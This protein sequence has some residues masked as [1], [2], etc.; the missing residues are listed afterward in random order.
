M[1]IETVAVGSH[2]LEVQGYSKIKDAFR[3]DDS[4]FSGKFKV[5]GHTWEILCDPWGSDAAD[6]VVVNL[7]I[8]V[9]RVQPVMARFSFALLGRD[10]ETSEYMEAMITGQYTFTSTGD[11]WSGEIIEREQFE[12]PLYLKDDRF[13]IRC[14]V[15]IVRGR[16]FLRKA[17]TVR[18]PAAPSPE[19]GRHLGGLLTNSQVGGDVT[20]KVGGELITAHKCI[21]AASSPVFKVEF[22]GPNPGND[23]N[24]STAAAAAHIQ[25]EDMKPEVF[26]AM[27]HFI[28]TDSLL[29]EIGHYSTK[30]AT[31][32]GLI[33]AA[34]RYKV[35]R[36][37]L[38]CGDKLCN[39]VDAGTAA[40]LLL[41]AKKHG[42][43]RLKETC[44]R[45]LRDLLADV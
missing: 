21:L 14:D 18:I 13:R 32:Q 17:A 35:D 34:D 11:Y 45:Y 41:L 4:T 6:W 15:A 42:C 19:L 25:I 43:R 38:I 30:G 44:M 36:L 5:G 12:S 40:T 16:E 39:Y 28:Y 1:A 31:L 29:P 24:T 7:G 20:F 33:V 10:A 22:F 27:L 2:V 37:R 8:R 26:K 9:M 23:K 3:A